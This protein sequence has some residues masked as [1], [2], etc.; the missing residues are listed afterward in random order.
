MA[1]RRL[2]SL[3]AHKVPH[4]QNEHVVKIEPT[5][6]KITILYSTIAATPAI[7]VLMGASAP[8]GTLAHTIL[9]GGICLK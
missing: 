6:S 5:R 3:V 7:E 1:K 8:N 4:R 9:H 2:K